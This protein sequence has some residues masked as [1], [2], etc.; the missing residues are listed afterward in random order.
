MPSPDQN[1]RR[2]IVSLPLGTGTRNLLSSRFVEQLS[3]Q[4]RYHVVLI[5]PAELTASMREA[6][7]FEV[8][9]YEY[10]NV[11]KLERVVWKLYT[12]MIDILSLS[13]TPTERYIRQRKYSL[14]AVSKFGKRLT[15]L[16]P[17]VS[18]ALVAMAAWCSQG[19]A[20]NS[21]RKNQDISFR[22][23]DRFLSTAA[24]LLLDQRLIYMA[25]V[26]GAKF[27][28]F[29]H[30]WDVPSSKPYYCFT[31]DIF[32]V[33]DKLTKCDL[34][35]FSFCNNAAEIRVVGSP[36]YAT[37][38]ELAEVAERKILRDEVPLQVLYATSQ[39]VFFPNEI[40]FVQTLA[41][42]YPRIEF[43]IRIHPQEKPEAYFVLDEPNLKLER[44]TAFSEAVPDKYNPLY[45]SECEFSAL[46]QSYD[47]IICIASSMAFDAVISGKKLAILRLSNLPEFSSVQDLYR[48]HHGKKLLQIFPENIVDDYCHLEKIFS[49]KASHYPAEV[50][51]FVNPNLM[52][53]ILN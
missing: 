12:T 18:D 42:R 23:S 38:H 33:P 41:R 49:G 3:S 1:K 22:R 51:D 21:T 46:L 13:D 29:V 35:R 10:E 17:K 50:E 27:D 15:H 7:P 48:T 39:A 30:S 52:E 4:N 14:A 26:S 25:T 5:A 45:E 6:Y 32:F 36:R 11:S 19:V 2:L 40:A 34:E 16:Y 47:V 28:V 24:H 53:A 20:K 9:P 43:T 44:S 8:L 37:L 31:P